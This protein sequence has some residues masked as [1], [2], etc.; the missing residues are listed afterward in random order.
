MDSMIRMEHNSNCDKW[1]IQHRA[2][3]Q[4][5]RI[6]GGI[7]Q[8][9]EL[10]LLG[11]KGQSRINKWRNQCV[12]IPLQFGILMEYLTQVSV[13]RLCPFIESKVY[14][15]IY[16]W[17]ARAVEPKRA[18]IEVPCHNI[19]VQK[20]LFF[21]HPEDHPIILDSDLVLIS[22][23]ELLKRHQEAQK[24]SILAWVLDLESC[25]AEER[26][27]EG[28]DFA[29]SEWAAIGFHLKQLLRTH[30]EHRKSLLTSKLEQNT[31]SLCRNC[32][33][34]NVRADQRI[35]EIVRFKNKDALHRALQV[36]QRGVPALVE[37]LNRRRVSLSRAAAL[38]KLPPDQ[39]ITQ[40]HPE[41]LLFGEAS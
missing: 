24:E 16:L 26:A 22:G 28:F 30:P 8:L 14:Q 5:I 2:I 33:T 37:A 17:I 23:L 20:E 31:L 41:T 29:I 3:N 34:T 21:P 32:D 13:R 10:L 36:C 19:V 27:F 11:P 38:A 35:A 7:I 4:V 6:C 1:E 12:K 18:P 15:L 25:W 9:A 40:I 39:Q